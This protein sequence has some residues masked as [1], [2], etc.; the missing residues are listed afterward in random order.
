MS[1]PTLNQYALYATIPGKMKRSTIAILTVR[2]YWVDI[3]TDDDLRYA[4]CTNRVRRLR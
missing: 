4:S 2:T 3:S 1:K